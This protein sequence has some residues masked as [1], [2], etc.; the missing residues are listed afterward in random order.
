[1][2]MERLRNV[3]LVLQALALLTLLIVPSSPAVAQC[4]DL[5]GCVLV[6]SDEFDGTAVDLSKWTFQLG[7]GSE[8]G[9]PP[10]WGNNELQWGRS[11]SPPPAPGR[12]G[13]R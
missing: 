1:M 11:P 9:L 10:G 7:D 12:A 4:V 2:T 6:W 13:P 8:V 5:P 3:T